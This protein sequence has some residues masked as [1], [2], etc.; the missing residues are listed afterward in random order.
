ME[1]IDPFNYKTVEQI[2]ICVKINTQHITRHVLYDNKCVNT[3]K[4]PLSTLIEMSS[5][6]HFPKEKVDN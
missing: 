2:Q 1:T 4:K 5:L 6:E 3:L